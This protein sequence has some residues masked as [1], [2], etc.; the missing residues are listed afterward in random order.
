MNPETKRA[1]IKLCQGSCCPRNLKATIPEPY[2]PYIPQRWNKTLVLAEAQ[3]H[4]GPYLSRLRGLSAQRR[5][6]RLGLFSGVGVQPWDDGC[7]KTAVWAVLGLKPENT[8]VSNAVLWSLLRDGGANDNP[9][10]E[11]VNHS[12]LL[13]S[14]M[15]DI[16]KPTR[17]VTAGRVSERVVSRAAEK[18]KLRFHHVIWP[19]PSP[20]VLYPLLGYMDE[21]RLF[22]RYPEI[23]KVK[24]QISKWVKPS[25]KKMAVFYAALASDAKS[26]LI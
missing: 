8:A 6:I 22:Q 3:N 9:S 11:I 19:L 7:L 21:E 2:I 15:L 14:K 10:P 23:A 17:V 18:C 24:R 1:L 5:I 16:L 12:V 13:W 4:S 25:S 26:N 20:R